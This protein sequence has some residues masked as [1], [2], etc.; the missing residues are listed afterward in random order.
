MVDAPE[1]GEFVL[2]DD[3]NIVLGGKVTDVLTD[4]MLMDQILYYSYPFPT[5]SHWQPVWRDA[6]GNL[7]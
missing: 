6:E 7:E 3:H 2:I 1:L 5:L 4:E